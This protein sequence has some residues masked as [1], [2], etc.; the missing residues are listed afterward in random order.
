MKLFTN[1]KQVQTEIDR[2]AQKDI[3]NIRLNMMRGNQ[4]IDSQI[5]TTKVMGKA[6]GY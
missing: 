1:K 2:I 6:L 5:Y 3:G 4:K